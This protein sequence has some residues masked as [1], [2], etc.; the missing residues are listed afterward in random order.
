MHKLQIR[1]SFKNLKQQK[2]ITGKQ[3]L[4]FI[5]YE[6]LDMLHGRTSN[7]F[8]LVLTHKIPQL[9]SWKVLQQHLNFNE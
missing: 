1:S 3:F 4:E 2:W 7:R 5:N 9:I 6:H 8:A